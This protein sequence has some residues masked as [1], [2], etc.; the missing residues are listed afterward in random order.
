VGGWGGSY[1][2]RDAVTNGSFLPGQPGHRR[3]RT[4]STRTHRVGVVGVGS[5]ACVLLTG[6]GALLGRGS[7]ADVS[8]CPGRNCIPNWC[9]GGGG[10]IS[11]AVS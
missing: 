9:G 2:R 5:A 10:G 4:A 11:W 6:L 7:A 3:S 8:F 1:R